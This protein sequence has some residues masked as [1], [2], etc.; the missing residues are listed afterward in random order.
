MTKTTSDRVF[1]PFSLRAAVLPSRHV[2][3]S[4]EPHDFEPRLSIAWSPEIFHGKT[5]I[6]AGSGIFYSDGQFGGL[7]AATTQIG[8]SFSL[9]QANIPT[10]SYPVTP[11]SRMPLIASAIRARIAIAK[12]WR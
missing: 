5:A 6:R 8:Q 9:S 1:D 2:L 7:Y 11:F 4:P 10:L 12:M 3:L